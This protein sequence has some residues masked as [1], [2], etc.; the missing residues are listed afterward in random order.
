MHGVSSALDNWQREFETEN[1]RTEEVAPLASEQVSY[2]KVP[3]KEQYVTKKPS[4]VLKGGMMFFCG[5]YER[6]ERPQRLS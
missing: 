6:R 5:A 3:E 1:G 2:A 4:T